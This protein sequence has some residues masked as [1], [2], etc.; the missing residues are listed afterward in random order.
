MKNFILIIAFAALVSLPV[1]S[2]DQEAPALVEGYYSQGDSAFSI[3]LGVQA[4]LFFN[5]YDGTFEPAAEHISLGARGDI[6]WG[7]FIT[8]NL[9][10]GANIGVSFMSTV[11]ARTLL[12]MPISLR[13]TWY[14]NF[15]KIDLSLFAGAGFALHRLDE[16]TAIAPMINLGSGLYWN[17]D[18]DWAFGIR[19]SWLTDQ[20][21]YFGNTV[22]ASDS[23]LGH[24][25]DISISALYRN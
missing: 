3:N 4:P 6:D 1:F 5:G 11:N 8:P 16:D 14:F 15:D 19:L 21:I 25:L 24:F 22:S 2:Q 12:Y 7:G 13:S 23:L 9:T 10:L 17:Y 20:E 18:S